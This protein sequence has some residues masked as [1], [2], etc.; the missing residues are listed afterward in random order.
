[1]DQPELHPPHHRHVLRTRT[2]EP[3]KDVNAT[4]L[5]VK[6]SQ[7]GTWRWA[8]YGNTTTGPST[9]AG[10]NVVVK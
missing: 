10:D 4:A 6:A 3:L 8:Y 1:Q 5:T 2:L 7:T 9:S